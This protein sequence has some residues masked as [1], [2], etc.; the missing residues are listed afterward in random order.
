M[1]IWKKR[2]NQIKF[3][4]LIW[5]ELTLFNSIGYYQLLKVLHKSQS[6]Y[7]SFHSKN[8]Y[9]Y[10][11]VTLPTSE[12]LSK[13]WQL[14]I[15]S[16]KNHLSTSWTLLSLPRTFITSTTT[17]SPHFL[18]KIF[19]ILLNFSRYSKEY[20]QQPIHQSSLSLNKWLKINN[21][22]LFQLHAE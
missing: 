15:L 19:L 14:Y 18:K 22:F 4:S 16:S 13:I 10:Y 3:S 11:C 12:E 5:S 20:F 7:N 21:F 9:F 1:I 17:L 6:V 8:E 2:H